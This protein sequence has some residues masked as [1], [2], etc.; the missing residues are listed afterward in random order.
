MKPLSPSRNPRISRS[1]L[2]MLSMIGLVSTALVVKAALADV[3]GPSDQDRRV[4]LAVTSFLNQDHLSRRNLD[5]EISQRCLKSYLDALD[6]MKL[7]F[8]QADIDHFSRWRNSLDDLVKQGHVKF[9]FD[10]FKVYLKRLDERMKDV[11]QLL[12][13]EHDFTV[14]EFLDTNFDDM[15][16]PQDAAEAKD[17]W[18]L[19]IKYDLLIQKAAKTEPK[20]AREKLA[21]RYR[22]YAQNKH[23]TDGEELI[24]TFLSA[25]ATS[26]DPHTSYM[27]PGTLENFNISM[28]LQLEGIGA[29]L[30]LEDGITVVSKIIAGGAADKEGSLQPEDQIIGV[31]QGRDGPIQDVVGMR[32]ND[33]V[34]QIRGKRGTVVRLQVTPEGGGEPKVY[35][36]TRAKI[37]LKDSEAR[38]EII[39][40]GNKPDGTP[41]K[42]GVIDLPSFYMDMEAARLGQPDFKSTTQD[43]KLLLRDFQRSG[44]DSVVLDLR[45]NGGGSLTEA[46][47]LSGLFIDKGP[48][49]QVKDADG[50]VQHYDDMDAGTAWSGPLV[51]LVSKFSASASEIFAGA[52]KDYRRGIVVGDH[53]T[54]GKGTVQTLMDLGRQLFRNPKAPEMGALK[55]TMQQFYRP[56]GF[57]TQNSG[58]LSDVELPSITTHLDV[59]ESDLD[60]AMKFDQ[61][62]AAPLET[63][64]QI[65]PAMVDQLRALSLQR[66]SESDD[67]KK[68]L[69]RIDKYK[70]QKA[71]KKISLNEVAFFA[72]RGALEDE[73]EK[74]RE[75]LGEDDG[76]KD[77]PVF[78][79]NFYNDETLNIAVDY[80][81]LLQ[82]GRLAAT[83]QPR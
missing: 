75:G 17:R 61:V 40:V 45:R 77:K 70:A 81:K 49:V 5:D 36:I 78:E 27:S 83:V 59:A 50:R 48:I 43:V 57:S 4:T 72:E 73:E 53:H 33:V 8:T 26:Y 16:Y 58:V 76:E 37:E 29:A 56:N 24:E 11:S 65:D 71:R 34:K 10:V 28:R 19:R 6:P 44:V 62:E 18:R 74:I 69:T 64:N 38:S 21:R 51:V 41:Y 47:N 25:L 3:E 39:E 46:I 22:T 80:T 42:I 23:Q 9:A 79:R 15:A 52:I 66:Q 14:D 1:T 60:Y 67:F 68:L 7:Y 30:M 54:H 35:E 31:G 82:G 13:E 63:A 20:E 12:E 55:I 32:L 2:V